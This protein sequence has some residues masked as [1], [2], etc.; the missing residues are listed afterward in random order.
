MSDLVYIDENADF[1]GEQQLIN[2]RKHQLVSTS[3]GALLQYQ[4]V[5]GDSV[6]LEKIQPLYTFLSAL[7]YLSD[8]EMYKISLE[9]EPRGATVKDLVQ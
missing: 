6:S 7:P 8:K 4:S 9:R 1:I 5:E 3:I 2:I